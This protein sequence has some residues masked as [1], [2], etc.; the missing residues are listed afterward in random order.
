MKSK[1]ALISKFKSYIKFWRRAKKSGISEAVTDDVDN[2]SPAAIDYEQ[3]TS[4]EVG[5]KSLWDQAYEGLQEE[6]P[7]VVT[8]Y[9]ELLCRILPYLETPCSSNGLENLLSD[10]TV[11]TKPQKRAARSPKDR[12]RLMNDIIVLGQKHMDEKRI[13]FKIGEQEFALRDQMQTVVAGI[14]VGKAWMNEAVKASPG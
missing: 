7:H 12:R 13:T 3:E 14:Q 5:P 1:G 2:A 10:P 11:N 6:K 4:I 9:E 8:A